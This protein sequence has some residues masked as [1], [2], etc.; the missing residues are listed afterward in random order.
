MQVILT[1]YNDIKARNTTTASE[2]ETI[3]AKAGNGVI[4][5]K[6]L[7]RSRGWLR[8]WNTLKKASSVYGKFGWIELYFEIALYNS[9]YQ[10]D[11][12]K[13]GEYYE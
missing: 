11:S 13:N 7:Q 10:I 2:R 3:T 5:E 4:I 1:S 6:W 8:P 9:Q 12:I